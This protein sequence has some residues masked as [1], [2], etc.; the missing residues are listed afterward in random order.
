MNEGM[1][2]VVV[3]GHMCLDVFPT[4][5]RGTALFRPGRTV[6]AG[7]IV[8]STGGPVSNTGLALHKLGASTRLMGKVGDDLF[9][10]A[11]LEILE[12]HGAGLASGMVISAGEASSYSIILSPPGADRMLIHSPGCNDT[13]SA[14]D[15]RYDLLETARAFHFGY[16]PLMKR[17]FANN[18]IELATM[19][20]RVKEPGLTT[21]LDLA[22]PDPLSAAGQADWRAILGATLP[23]VDIILPSFEEMLLMLRRPLAAFTLVRAELTAAEQQAPLECSMALKMRD[24]AGLQARIGKGRLIVFHPGRFTSAANGQIKV[25][26]GYDLR[27]TFWR[28]RF[29]GNLAFGLVV[30]TIWS[31][32]DGSGQPMN[33]HQIAQLNAVTQVAQIQGEYL[34]RSTR[35]NTEIARQR[36][37]EQ[38]LPFVQDH[39]EF[40]LPCMVTAQVSP[41]PIR[42]ILGSNEV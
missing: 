11:I 19:L 22:Q 13:F 2:D 31:I 26:Q 29:S 4:L 18:G 14:A 21:S 34:P 23:Y 25:H 12:A 30:D 15:M 8:F 39:P 33:T 10:Q 5:A 32:R 20:R 17:M 37:Q 41:Q 16:P 1:I 35:I 24:L 40:E 38:I 6:E 28:D 36:L 27:S 9:G 3:A 7:P 42:I